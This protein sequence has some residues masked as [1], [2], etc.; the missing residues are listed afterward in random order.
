MTRKLAVY[1]LFAFLAVACGNE[2]KTSQN[3][4]ELD[5]KTDIEMEVFVGDTTSFEDF[6][7]HYKTVELPLHIDSAFALS[8]LAFMVND[9]LSDSREFYIPTYHIEQWLV[10]TTDTNSELGGW[11]HTFKHLLNEDDWNW[12]SLH[13]GYHF[14]EGSYDYFITYRYHQVSAVNGGY[15]TYFL[16]ALNEDH[17]V[18]YVKELGTDNYYTTT[19]M[20]D[21]EEEYW[22]QRIYEIET[23]EIDIQS[24]DEITVTTYSIEKVEGD[25]QPH[26][27]RLIGKSNVTY[28]SLDGLT[29]IF[30]SK[31]VKL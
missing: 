19:D 30:K 7:S 20:K 24:A 16:H 31:K 10:D 2:E 17:D 11:Y 12:Y 29:Q 8:G 4:E 1:G 27:Q 22:W 3:S 15:W 13:Y 5:G 28:D 26:Q 23:V 21:T 25:L 9:S 14:M 18:V 6:K